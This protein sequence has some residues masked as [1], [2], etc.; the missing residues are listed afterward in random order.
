IL[1]RLVHRRGQEHRQGSTAASQIAPIYARVCRQGPGAIDRDMIRAKTILPTTFVLAALMTPAA[2][3]AAAQ[4]PDTEDLPRILITDPNRDLFRL[5]LPSAGGDPD[6]AGLAT[7][8]ERRDLDLV[9]LFRVIDPASF[10][11]ALVKA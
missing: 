4:S 11:D 9:G 10:P 7:E 2:T 5:G 3:Q 8:V 6:L 1:R